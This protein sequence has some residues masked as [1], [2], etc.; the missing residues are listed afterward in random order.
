M[1]E[2]QSWA[3]ME[4]Y[5]HQIAEK[6]AALI[7][8]YGWEDDFQA[9]LAKAQA[10][11]I[12]GFP[13][14]PTL[15]DFLRQT[16]DLVTYTPA[17]GA[18]VR[19]AF[20]AHLHYYYVLSQEP[21]RC[22]QSPLEPGESAQELTPLS[23]WMVEFVQARGSYMDTL[24]SAQGIEVFRAHPALAWDEYM[25]PP[26]GYLTF[27]Q[28]FARHV[29]PGA[30]P[31]EGLN[32]D[33]V[34]VS[35]ADSTYLGVWQIN[36][37]SELQVED[38]RLEIKGL[39]WSIHELLQGSE[40]ADRFKGGIFTHSFLKATDYH[41]WHT[42]VSGK[43]VEA[44][45]VQGQVYA[46][47]VALPQMVDGRQVQVLDLLDEVGY[48]FLQTRG[49][50]MI[51]SPAGLVACIPVGMGMVSSVVITAEVGK[52]LHKGEELGYFQFGG[53]DFV[54][55]FERNSHVELTCQAN[56]H[57]KQGRRIGHFHPENISV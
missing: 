2:H 8:Q 10:S 13:Q 56:Q 23:A 24:E 16:S 37:N 43:V 55:V 51:D 11:E 34:L 39:R 29:K 3:V 36:E 28:F 7:R 17:A 49:I 22:L 30:R 48:Q 21:L 50:V 9:A 52:T 14:I 38:D 25:P 33:T 54:M 27:N 41:R 42:P 4:G 12:S 15:E 31:I 20:A 53:S 44:R 1:A 32:D 57:L 35:P 18:D 47:A 40:Y 5:M 26:S 19:N 46:E 45:V 6:L